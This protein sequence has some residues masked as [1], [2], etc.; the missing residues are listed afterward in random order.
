MSSVTVQGIIKNTPNSPTH[1]SVGGDQ[2]A[3]FH[4]E[5]APTSLSQPVGHGLFAISGNQWE[6][7]GEL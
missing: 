1:P 5:N 3:K 2:T 4:G 6:G 7:V